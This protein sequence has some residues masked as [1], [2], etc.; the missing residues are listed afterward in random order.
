MSITDTPTT[1]PAPNFLNT[2]YEG[3]GQLRN[4]RAFDG[5]YYAGTEYAEVAC[6]LRKFRV[7][8]ASHRVHGLF[9]DALEE[10]AHV[11][12]AVPD[13]VVA[14]EFDEADGVAASEGVPVASERVETQTHVGQRT[15]VAVAGDE[16]IQPG[17]VVAEAQSPNRR[18]TGGSGMLA[19]RATGSGGLRVGEQYLR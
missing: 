8:H 3:A 6:A 7:P 5:S 11:L 4:G 14:V 17:A 12:D 1:T 16:P 15:V 18:T 19:S 10:A 2:A 9:A 13:R